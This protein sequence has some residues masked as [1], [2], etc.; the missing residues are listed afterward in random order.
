L[1]EVH[2]FKL[3]AYRLVVSVSEV[4]RVQSC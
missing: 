1:P 3:G 4:S 2:A